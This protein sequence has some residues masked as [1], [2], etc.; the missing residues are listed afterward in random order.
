M[1]DLALSV[2]FSSFLYVVFKLFAVY[3]VETLLA[4]IINY[5]VA[6]SVGLL[7]FDTGSTL[8]GIPQK[9]WFLSTLALGFLFVV[10]FNLIAA[11]VQK[12]GVSVTSVA[13]KM[14]LV[15]PVLFGVV[16]YEEVLGPLK[17][18]GVLLALAAVYFASAKEKQT[19]RKNSLL[20]LPILVFTGSGIIDVSLKF[21]QDTHINDNEASLFS[22]TL[23]G[24]AAVVGVAYY[25]LKSIKKPK[26][27]TL[28]TIL[29]GIVLGVPNYFSIHFL[30]RALESDSLNSASVFTI[31]NVAIVLFSTLLG[32]ILFKEKLSLKN[33]GGVAL[34]VLS[35]VLVAIF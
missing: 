16:W 23:F 4:I 15:I 10:V 11:T 29:G 27:I 35:I 22:A 20:L 1:L 33:W 25:I 8:S 31:N 12:A 26:K 6:C 14:S 2:L 18:L 17:I 24:S 32:I 30:L 34:A 5:V 3:R 21:I 28:I 9:P 13:T 7:F 19:S